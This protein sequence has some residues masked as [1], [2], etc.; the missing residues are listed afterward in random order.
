MKHF[1]NNLVFNAR[2][3]VRVF[4][5]NV[6]QGF[7]GSGRIQNII[8]AG[9]FLKSAFRIW[10]SNTDMGKNPVMSRD[11]VFFLWDSAIHWADD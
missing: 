8:R 7:G 11:A 5:M 9:L 4:K 2:V 6:L 1:Q 3:D 10:S